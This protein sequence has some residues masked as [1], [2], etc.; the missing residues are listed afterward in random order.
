MQWYY[1][2]CWSIKVQKLYPCWILIMCLWFYIQIFSSLGT[3]NL[4]PLIW[5]CELTV[6]LDKC[7]L[8]FVPF[9]PHLFS[10]NFSMS[11]I[12]IVKSTLLN[13]QTLPY[14]TKRMG[15]G[16][17]GGGLVIGSLRNDAVWC[18]LR[19]V[20]E[21]QCCLLNTVTAVLHRSACHNVLYPQTYHCRCTEGVWAT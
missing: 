10:F 3:W 4:S 17:G 5:I 15:G 2:L 16:L 19:T 1:P 18:Q 21:H 11:A 20:K 9:S 6:S 8:S 14:N 12:L 13:G 7:F